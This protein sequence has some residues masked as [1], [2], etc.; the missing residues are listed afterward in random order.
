MS[1][2]TCPVSPCVAMCG[3]LCSCTITSVNIVTIHGDFERMSSISLC[4]VSAGVSLSTSLPKLLVSA[5]SP[6]SNFFCFCFLETISAKR[7]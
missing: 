7:D 4:L 3:F 6:S 5:A 1:C 2:V